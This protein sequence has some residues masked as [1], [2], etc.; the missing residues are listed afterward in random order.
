MRENLEVI[1]KLRRRHAV[2]R[3]FEGADLALLKGDHCCQQAIAITE[4][5]V[6]AFLGTVGR[7]R[8]TGCG[9]RFLAALDQ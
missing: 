2:A 3:L 8:Q 4:P 9:E 5:L 6:E 1:G 7:T